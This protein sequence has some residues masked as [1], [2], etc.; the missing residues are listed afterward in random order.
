MVIPITITY[1]LDIVKTLYS[2]P[3]SPYANFKHVD[4]SYPIHVILGL[5]IPITTRYNV[6]SKASL[7]TSIDILFIQFSTS[8]NIP[9]SYHFRSSVFMDVVILVVGLN[10]RR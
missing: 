9:L 6:I 5:L 2:L 8:F 7:Y 1:D 4:F 3:E 10:Y